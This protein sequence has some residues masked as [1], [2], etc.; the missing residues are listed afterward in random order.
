MKN[1]TVALLGA[2]GAVG[3]EFLK[4]MEERDFPFGKLKL[5]AS[6]RSAGTTV[7]PFSQTSPCGSACRVMWFLV[8]K[9]CGSR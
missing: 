6:K 2:T 5:L 4:L 3:E 1:Y 7:L 9:K 8:T